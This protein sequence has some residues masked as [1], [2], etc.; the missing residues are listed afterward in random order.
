MAAKT[1]EC[2]GCGASLQQGLTAWH[3]VCNTCS[4]EGS[5]LDGHI[6]T[7]QGTEVLDEALREDGLSHLRQRNFGVLAA[8][9]ADIAVAA[10]DAPRPRLLDVGCAHGWFLEAARSDFDVT[11]IEPDFA[12]GASAQRRN[13]P[14]RLGFFPDVL[15]RDEYF[16]VIVFNDVLEHI[17]DIDSALKAC[18][19]HL[20]PQGLVV[21][22]APART[23]VIYRTAGLLAKMGMPGTFERMWQKDFPSPHVHYLDDHSIKAIASHAGLVPFRTITLPSVS[24]QGLLA[25]IRYDRS[26]SPLKGMVM[27]TIILAAIPVLRILPSD[28]KVWILRRPA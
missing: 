28:I 13:L 22:N 27:A 10:P 16:D 12:V 20:S 18:V 7:E 14:V 4:Y 1:Y 23:G 15:D 2:P 21:V 11:G 24:H 6:Q 19:R 8:L 3:R 26:V 25:R 9:L 5:V 17:P